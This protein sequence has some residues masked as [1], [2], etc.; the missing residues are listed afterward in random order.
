MIQVFFY[1]LMK[2]HQEV[3]EIYQCQSPCILRFS[4]SPLS[5]IK[6][7]VSVELKVLAGRVSAL[8][9]W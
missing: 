2:I 6:S 1:N 7:F 4:S 9:R 8:A 5:T 3:N